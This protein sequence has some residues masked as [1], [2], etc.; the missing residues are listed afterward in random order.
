M[1]VSVNFVSTDSLGQRGSRSRE[2]HCYFLKNGKG[3]RGFPTRFGAL[4]SAMCLV[5]YWLFMLF[6][7]LLVGFGFLCHNLTTPTSHPQLTKEPAKK[8][9]KKKKNTSKSG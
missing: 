6:V 9:K 7:V 1:N 3:L 2:F 4:K 5:C 8:K